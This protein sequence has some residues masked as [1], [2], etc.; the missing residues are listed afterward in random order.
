MLLICKD[1]YALSLEVAH[2]IIHQVQIKPQSV[3]CLAAGDT[4]RLAYAL[5]VELSQQSATNFTQCTFV[6]LDEW[7]G[8]HP[9]NEGSCAYFLRRNLLSP[10]AIADAQIRLFDGLAQDPVRECVQMDEFVRK[11]GGI[12]LVLVGVGMNG[13]VGF[14]E[15]GVAE[16]LYAHVT[17]LDDTTRSVGQ[18]YFKETTPLQRGITLGLR[19]LL[20]AGTAL[21]MA[22]G[23]K[24]AA[25]IRKIVE[26]PVSTDVPASIIRKHPDGVILLDNEAASML[27]SK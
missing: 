1:H 5:L 3:L 13:H 15:P 4:P 25:I 8:I 24:K 22:S 20:D 2:R 21:L 16:D 27:K 18:K 11:L 19:H 14:N 12:D 17:D 23:E 9:E 6:G 26:G 10:L 7:L